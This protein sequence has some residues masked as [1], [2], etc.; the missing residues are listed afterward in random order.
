MENKFIAL[1]VGLTVGVIMLSGFL[2]PLVADA[3]AIN[4]TF[5]NEGYFAM[6]AVT[7][8]TNTTIEFDNTLSKVVV[9]GEEITTNTTSPNSFTILGAD[10]TIVR[11]QP[12]N[13]VRIY[14]NDVKWGFANTDT[15]T[16]LKLE[17]NGASVTITSDK[18]SSESATISLGNTPFVI[19]ADEDA[20]YVMKYANEG[21]YVTDQSVYLMGISIGLGFN[22]AIGVYG[23]GSIAEG[24]ELS[25]AYQGTSVTGEITYAEPIADYVTVGG[26]TGLYNLNGYTSSITIDGGSP[27]EISYTYFVVPAEVTAE[28]SWHLDT[29]QVALVAAIGTLGAIVLIAAAAGSI[30]RLD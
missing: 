11:W 21:A 4:E 3:T 7:E 23:I 6:D 15:F 16:Y 12:N 30:R 29:T 8:D 24:M 25:T 18:A 26:Y 19:S 27:T 13:S 10:N 1:A 20:Q 2:W 28:K 5:T 17:V 9:N 22:T 14:S